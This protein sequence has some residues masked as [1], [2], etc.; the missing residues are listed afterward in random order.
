MPTTTAQL[1][2][3]F[4]LL[5]D[6]QMHNKDCDETGSAE[7]KAYLREVWNDV[8]AHRVTVGLREYFPCEYSE[9]CEELNVDRAPWE[10]L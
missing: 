7:I 2:L 4:D 1:I 9:V 6:K 8:P 5:A 3:V 10:A